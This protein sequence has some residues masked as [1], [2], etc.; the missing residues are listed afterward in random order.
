M[1]ASKHESRPRIA[2]IEDNADNL[3]LLEV[4]L[5]DRYEVA[6]YT[7]GPDALEGLGQGAVE[8]VLLDVSLPGMDGL[9]VLQELRKNPDLAKL[10]IVAITAHA[11]TGDR[12]R[13]LRAGF[14]DYISKPILDEADLFQTIERNLPDEG[15]AGSTA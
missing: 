1:M 12:E 13:L 10:P 3:L 5:S 14:D 15:A 9:E 7:S 2:V 11:M 4:L 6:L 8:L